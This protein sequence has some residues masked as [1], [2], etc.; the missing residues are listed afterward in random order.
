[1]SAHTEEDRGTPEAADNEDL[2]PEAQHSFSP[3][4]APSG[5]GEREDLAEPAADGEN[6]LL[7]EAPHPHTPENMTSNAEPVAQPN[8]HKVGENAASPMDVAEVDPV[9]ET[10]QYALDHKLNELFTHLIQ[11]LIYYQPE[12]PRAFLADEVKKIREEKISSSLFTE[13]DL[14]TMFELIDVTKQKW[15][16]VQQLR[17]TCRN[18]A[19]ST[20]DQGGS[21]LDDQEALISGAADESGHVSLEGFKE[22]LSAQLLTKNM[23]SQ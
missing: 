14:E 16:T 13:R 18:I 3:D 17:N 12:D 20:G 9:S 11:L 4:E 22:A 1:M 10:H 8:T 5:E 23:W 6:D 2:Y 15:I 19:T 21:L 7:C